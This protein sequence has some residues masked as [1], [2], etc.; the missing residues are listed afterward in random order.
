MMK[1]FPIREEVEDHGG[2]RRVFVIDC[3]RGELGYTVRATEEGKEGLGYE[4]GAYSETSPFSALGRVRQKMCRALATR[5][6][7]VADGGCRMLHDSLEG[8][9]TS[10]ADGQV[11]L[12]VDGVPLEMEKVESLLQSHEGWSF[13]LRIVDSLE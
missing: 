4:F 13:S 3:R 8:R 7:S 5:H 10:D 9:I 1:D 2:R 6:L 11:V 12:V